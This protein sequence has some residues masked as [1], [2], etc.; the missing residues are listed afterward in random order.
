MDDGALNTAAAR[1]AFLDAL[2]VD[3]QAKVLRR[4]ERDGPLATDADWLIAYA[5]SRAAMRIEAAALKV[6]AAADRNARATSRVKVRT[7]GRELIAF[8]LALA[9]FSMIAW[10]TTSIHVLRAPSLVVY[11]IALALGVAI[12]AAYFTFMNRAH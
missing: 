8:A 1:D 7:T 12:A 5:T 2:P 11:A 4:A 10:A 6:E 9:S 3:E